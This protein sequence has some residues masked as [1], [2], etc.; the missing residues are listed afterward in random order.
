MRS[1]SSSWIDLSTIRP[2]MPGRRHH[3]SNAA[4]RKGGVRAWRDKDPL[5]ARGAG[6]EDDPGGTAGVTKRGKRQ[7]VADY[8]CEIW[9]LQHGNGS[10]TEAC[11]AE[12]LAAFGFG[13]LL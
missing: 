10:R 9:E 12:G 1:D 4:V 13:A 6:A 2:V 7:T 5:K 11:I 8:D 3:G